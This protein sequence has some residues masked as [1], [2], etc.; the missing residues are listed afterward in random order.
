MPRELD[1]DD[2]RVRAGRGSRPRTRERP[3]HADAVTATVVAV[4]RGRYTCHVTGHLAAKAPAAGTP[5]GPS[6][7]TGVLVAGVRGGSLRRTSVIV[8][9]EVA[10]VGDVSGS[11]GSL[12]RIVGR[13][14]RRSVLRRTPDDTD[15]LER[16]IVANADRLV[17]VCALTDPP[18]RTGLIDRCLVA[19][20]DGGLEP[21]LC[22]TKADLADDTP[23]RELYGPLGLPVVTTRPDAGIDAL[24][25]LLAGC[26][27]VMFG[28]SGVGKSTL[29]NRVVPDAARTIGAVNAVTGRGRH[30][31]SAAI[32][33]P[34]PGG[35]WVV[36]TPGVRSFGLGAVCADR[37]LAAF[38]DLAPAAV[39]CPG[40]CTHQAGLA[41]CALDQ[42]VDDGQADPGR[43]ASLRRLL[44]ARSAADPT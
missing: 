3:D 33:L 26:V 9:D 20:Y 31:S 6:T 27:C 24:T 28:H 13:S 2:V 12:A 43:L 18:P 4:D 15:P 41:D 1:E 19:A 5:A 42:A 10:L 37:V 16:P 40:G 36:D 7:S 39:A 44:A 23:L 21:V 11:P 14:E 32:A 35:G 38:P 8:G 29:V 34:M 25:A 30:T 22:L 17:I